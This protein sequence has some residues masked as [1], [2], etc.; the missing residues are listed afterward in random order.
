MILPINALYQVNHSSPTAPLVQTDARFIGNRN[1]LSSDFLIQR[2]REQF[3]PA[4]QVQRFADGFY[5]QL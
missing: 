1:W 4:P 2:I 3:G 5:E